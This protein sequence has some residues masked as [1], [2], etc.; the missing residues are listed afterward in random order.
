MIS[1]GVADSLTKMPKPLVNHTNGK[2]P[3]NTKNDVSKENG[4]VQNPLSGTSVENT[5]QD[6]ET[7]IDNQKLASQENEVK[8][9]IVQ[10]LPNET[11]IIPNNGKDNEKFDA[12]SKQSSSMPTD[13]LKNDVIIEEVNE[14]VLRENTKPSKKVTFPD[15]DLPPRGL[16]KREHTILPSGETKPVAVETKAASNP[17]ENEVIANFG[18]EKTGMN[19]RKPS[20]NGTISTGGEK[21]NDEMFGKNVIV[22]TQFEEHPHSLG[23]RDHTLTDIII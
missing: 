21:S 2:P 9:N 4:G 17:A 14:E 1:G 5:L 10:K 18:K 7:D 23:P 16:E 12:K 8:T 22:G 6:I 13:N 20:S 15:E 11:A 19:S 3:Q